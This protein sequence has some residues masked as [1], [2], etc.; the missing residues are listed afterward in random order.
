MPVTWSSRAPVK[1]RERQ[2]FR[3]S[4][5]PL[6]AATR[7][8]PETAIKLPGGGCESCPL[9]DRPPVAL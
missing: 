8:C 5:R 1:D 4:T 7:N 2:W 3:A 6:T 9:A